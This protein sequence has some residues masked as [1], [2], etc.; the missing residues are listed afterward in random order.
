MKTIGGF[1]LLLFS[2]FILIS[3]V[4]LSGTVFAVDSGVIRVPQDYL[5]IQEA[6]DVASPGYTI[7]VSAGTYNEYVYVN[8]SVNLIGED[9]HSMISGLEIRA[10]NVTINGF[11]TAPYPGPTIELINSRGC[12]ISNN[13]VNGC[14][15]VIS[16]ENSCNNFIVGNKL[17]EAMAGWGIYLLF[18]SDNNIIRENNIEGQEAGIIF[19][20]GHNNTFEENKI[21]GCT[22]GILVD[23]SHNIIRRNTLENNL[24]GIGSY[25]SAKDNYLY[26]N[27]LINNR[28]QTSLYG[29]NIWDNGIEG[30]Y[31]DDYNG[32][33]LD[34]D[35]IGDTYLPWEGVDYYPLMAPWTRVR[36][37]YVSVNETVYPVTIYSDSTIASFGF[38]ESLGRVSFNATGPHN[39]QGLCNVTIPKAV[40]DGHLLVLVDAGV[41]DFTRV[42]NETHNCV[43]FT[44][45]HSTH[46]IRIIEYTTPI[47]GDLNYDGKVSLYDIVMAVAAYGSTPEDPNW[48]P[49]ADVAPQYELVDIYDLV[50][51]ASHY[52]ETYQ[53]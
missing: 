44:Y 23:G 38:N 20:G 45:T 8:K 17:P 7:L 29:R 15:Y 4:L 12:N 30:N 43:W 46:R 42:E 35:G 39:V 11:T 26:H 28:H 48:N 50:T 2:A 19:W 36:T 32:T 52:G 14:F 1:L 40:L 5:T 33:D 13:I 9:C 24:Y 47:M 16:L 22:W 34:G 49:L 53:C 21:V 37:F 18:D 31:W 27:N 10:D 41:I 51:I 25:S 6:V 3:C